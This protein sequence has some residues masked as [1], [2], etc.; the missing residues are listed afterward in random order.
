M[1]TLSLLAVTFMFMASI[2]LA[3][4]IYVSGSGTFVA[5]SVTSDSSFTI[6]FSGSNG[7]DSVSVSG[8]GC[9]HW[10]GLFCT[11]EVTGSAVIDGV[12]FGG[13]PFFGGTYSF[14]LSNGSGFVS[15]FNPATNQHE[16]V[17]IIGYVNATTQGCIGNFPVSGQCFGTFVVNP[18]PEPGALSLACFG[19]CAA[20]YIVVGKRKFRLGRPCN[21]ATPAR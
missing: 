15:G 20:L 2:A 3:D 10:P 4:P 16:F 18:T 11:G 5:D 8:A 21:F 6:S 7:V 9:N 19:L 17:N 13:G 1:R 14:S 12:A